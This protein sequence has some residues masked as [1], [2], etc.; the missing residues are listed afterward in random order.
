M[1]GSS[2]RLRVALRRSLRFLKAAQATKRLDLPEPG[3]AVFC[4]DG[5][6]LTVLL[7]RFIEMFLLVK[8]MAPVKI[9]NLA[10]GV[11]PHGGAVILNGSIELPSRGKH[12]AD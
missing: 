5:D 6:S 4:I 1:T 7:N 12:C 2:V 3:V 9:G 10:V 11:D 8:R